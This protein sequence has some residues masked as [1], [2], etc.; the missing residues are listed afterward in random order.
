[1]NMYSILHAFV[2]SATD[3]WVVL[4]LLLSLYCI[5]LFSCKAACVFAINLLTY[6]TRVRRTYSRSKNNFWK[7]CKQTRWRKAINCSYQQYSSFAHRTVIVV[8]KRTPFFGCKKNATAIITQMIVFYI[9]NMW[10]VFK[11][12]MSNRPEIEIWQ[13]LDLYSEEMRKD[14]V[15]PPNYCYLLKNRSRWIWPRCQNFD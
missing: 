15:R 8:Q 13:M 10:N 7:L 14:V 6:F 4:L 1:M 3:C 11:V 12:I 2:I 5:D 9:G